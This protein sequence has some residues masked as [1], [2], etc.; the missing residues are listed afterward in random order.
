MKREEN[1]R[2]MRT[3]WVESS[4]YVTVNDFARKACSVLCGKITGN[5]EESVQWMSTARGTSEILDAQSWALT[6][7]E[8]RGMLVLV[9]KVE[10]IAI[11][12][13]DGQLAPITKDRCYW[14]WCEKAFS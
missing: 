9:W 11:N 2:E 13:G 3:K 6:L 7:H 1:F 10:K 4:V 14:C 12:R 8:K 5:I